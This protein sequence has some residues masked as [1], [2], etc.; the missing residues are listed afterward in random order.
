MKRRKTQDSDSL[1]PESKSTP[2]QSKYF[3]GAQSQ[4]EDASSS[5]SDGGV[6][7]ESEQ[8]AGDDDAS[9]YSD[10]GN[11]DASAVSALDEEEEDVDEG[12]DDETPPPKRRGRGRAGARTSDNSKKSTTQPTPAKGQEYW[13]TGVKAGLGP[14]TEMII[15]KPKARAAGKTP[16]RDDQ[17]HPNTFLFLRDLAANNDREWLKRND[18]DYRT[19]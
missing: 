1:L 14:G 17:I 12:Y 16:Y 3:R 7:S 8:S 15:E 19:S 13:R 9:A 18:P 2:R 11:S 5:E 10:D 6:E 4:L